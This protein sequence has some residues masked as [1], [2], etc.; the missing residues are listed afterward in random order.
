MRGGEREKE[1]G[2]EKTESKE[3]LKA[4]TCFLTEQRN[5]HAV[6]KCLEGLQ[7][8]DIIGLGLSL[9]LYYPT[10]V[11]MQLLP[12]DMVHAWLMKTDG[13]TE[14]PSTETLIRALESQNHVGIVDRV[15]ASFIIT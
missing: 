4:S 2:R 15:K 9:G 8:D 1:R 14:T 3:A 6:C 11:K 7:R 5:L 13:V 10:L 12:H